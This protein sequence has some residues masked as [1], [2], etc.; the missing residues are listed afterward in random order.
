MDEQTT[1][2]LQ[3]VIEAINSVD[4]HLQGLKNY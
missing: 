2:Y 4:E 3:D 1:K